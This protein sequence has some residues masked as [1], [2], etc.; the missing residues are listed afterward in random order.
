M[1]AE[2][3]AEARPVPMVVASEALPLPCAIGVSASSMTIADS[4]SK[5]ALSAAQMGVARPLK[6][7]AGPL[8]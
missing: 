8:P 2:A 7:Y 4:P 3:R 5:M 6:V 1:A